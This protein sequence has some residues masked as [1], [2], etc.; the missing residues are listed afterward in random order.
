METIAMEAARYAD[1]TVVRL[2]SILE[3][4]IEKHEPSLVG[5]LE[6][7]FSA[8]T[9]ASGSTLRG[10]Q[11]AGI[12]FQLLGIAEELAAMR[13]RRMI[14]KELG[15]D[16]VPGTFA[17]A[18]AEAKKAGMSAADVQKLLE[19]TCV[20][21]VITAHPT[22]AKRVSVLQIHRS[23]YVTL[24][25][26]EAERW[27][28]QERAA[29][30]RRLYAD[31]ELL[32]LTGE[33]RL[34]KPQVRHEVSWGLH[35]FKD[36]VIERLPFALNRLEL[37]LEA[38]YPETE[39]DLPPIIR[40]GSWIGGD[41][42]G[43]PFV[44]L[45]V[46]RDALFAHR[47]VALERYLVRLVELRDRLSVAGHS[48]KV[49]DEFKERLDTLLERSERREMLDKRNP[50]ELFR[51]FVNCMQLKLEATNNAAVEH[52]FPA[53]G[54][55]AYRTSDELA[56]DLRALERGLAAASCETIAE[57]HVKPLR[58]K[59]ETFRFCTVSLD[60]R[61]N[62]A[63]TN[64]ALRSLW[65]V[66][67]GRP[68]D[69]CPPA[70]D[71]AW[72]EWLVAELAEPQTGHF[73]ASPLSEQAREL[74]ELLALL[75]DARRDLDERSVGLAILSMTESADDVLGIYVLAKYAGLLQGADDTT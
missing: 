48:V 50:G 54:A 30:E 66:I 61:Q 57:E 63:V 41:R 32:W 11:L 9:G 75:A 42:D 56:A 38:S 25:E 19:T 49:D 1:A 64:A 62:T 43:N 34:E 4:V 36:A 18:I 74:I 28:P 68:E 24:F 40:F 33:L 37:A 46:T 5:F 53:S 10:L 71:P 69:D 55:F 7:P 73:D 59:V 31:I 23:I 47:L 45:G 20:Q 67:N 17:F 29:F 8:A 3:A 21:P 2:K 65:S 27:T 51:Q 35:F 22:E 58:R 39:F 14:E 16:N 52:A 72:H 60:V 15:P 70:G 12:W 6:Q 44:T 26:L 13:R